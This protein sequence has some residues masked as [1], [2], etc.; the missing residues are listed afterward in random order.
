MLPAAALL[1]A[2]LLGGACGASSEAVRTDM[3]RLTTEEIASVEAATLFEVVQRLRPRWLEV[4]A[5]RSGFEGPPT[6]IVVVMDRTYLGGVDELRRLGRETAVSLE[7]M[8]GA[9]A[10]ALLSGL[11]SRHVEGAIIVHTR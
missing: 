4:R 2:V 5:V 10:S 1:L 6:E 7:Y 8:T 11:G 3:D 9:R